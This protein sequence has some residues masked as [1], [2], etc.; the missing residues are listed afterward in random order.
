MFVSLSKKDHKDALNYAP[1]DHVGI[2]AENRKDLVDAVL[3]KISNGP[4]S[5]DQ[6]LKVQFQK[7]FISNLGK[8]L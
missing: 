5:H 3:S 1:G 7:K 8:I 2:L 4:Q 6:P